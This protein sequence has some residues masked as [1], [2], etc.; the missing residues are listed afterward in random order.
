MEW[1]MKQMGIGWEK[2]IGRWRENIWKYHLVCLLGCC[3]LV[4]ITL[5]F[6]IVS[7]KKLGKS[8]GTPAAFAGGLSFAYYFVREVYGKGKKNSWAVVAKGDVIWKRSI[9]SLRL[10]H[11]LVG[12]LAFYLVFLHGIFLLMVLPDLR[13]SRV[14]SGL[15][16]GATAVFLLLSGSLLARK[17]VLRS[18]HRWMACFAVVLFLVHVYLKIKF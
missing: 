2:C 6:D 1:E 4:Y 13:S 15:V 14:I 3:I 17:K 9:K 16:E 12:I 5:H 10:L 7:L 8:F 18:Y 11:P